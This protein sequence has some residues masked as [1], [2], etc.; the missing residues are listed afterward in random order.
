MTDN[1]DAYGNVYV[2]REDF[3]AWLDLFGAKH[4]HRNCSSG[5]IQVKEGDLT[6][7]INF[8]EIIK[9][10]REMFYAYGAAD[11]T[12]DGLPTHYRINSGSDGHHIKG[13]GSRSGEAWKRVREIKQVLIDCAVAL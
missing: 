10:G 1:Q 3:E 13:K 11:Q 7:T 12:K 6:Y 9:I 5:S 4:Y 2:P 8:T